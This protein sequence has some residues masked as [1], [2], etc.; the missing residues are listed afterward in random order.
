[1]NHLLYKCFPDCYQS[2]PLLLAGS[3]ILVERVGKCHFHWLAWILCI[4]VMYWH[5]TLQRVMYLLF[6]PN[7]CF[8]FS[9]PFEECPNCV[10]CAGQ[11]NHIYI[12]VD[13][14]NFRLQ[15]RQFLMYRILIVWIQASSI[16]NASKIFHPSSDKNLKWFCHDVVHEAFLSSISFYWTKLSKLVESL[17]IQSFSWRCATRN[18]KRLRSMLS[19]VLAILFHQKNGYEVIIDSTR[20]IQT[21]R[22]QFKR[23][24]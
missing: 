10:G 7:F 4:S 23:K 13:F 3:R 21:P 14:T 18:Q 15:Y 5:N 20:N 11:L 2:G 22:S 8:A 6:Y 1:M 19:S 9:F 24:R 17:H 16:A 12:I